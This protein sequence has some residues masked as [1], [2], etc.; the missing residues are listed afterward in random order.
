MIQRHINNIANRFNLFNPFINHIEGVRPLLRQLLD[1]YY[2]SKVEMNEVRERILGLC[3]SAILTNRIV[4]FLE[5]EIPDLAFEIGTRAGIPTTRQPSLPHHKRWG[6]VQ[7]VNSPSLHALTNGQNFVHVETG[8]DLSRALS[9]IRSAKMAVIDSISNVDPFVTEEYVGLTIFVDGHLFLLKTRT[10]SVTTININDFFSQ[11]GK[12]PLYAHG[13]KKIID[14]VKTIYPHFKPSCIVDHMQLSKI[15]KLDYS[16]PTLADCLFSEK[17][18]T[19]TAFSNKNQS[20]S[21]LVRDHM[22]IPNCLLHE[23]ACRHL[24]SDDWVEAAKESAA[25]FFKKGRK[26]KIYN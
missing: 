20:I 12:M 22:I 8:A 14:F 21:Q 17:Y 3:T 23:F 16:L 4:A 26:N 10:W 13:G 6:E 11:L 9:V 15:K 19:R 2:D 1:K 24:S 7:C 18:C 5:I 25:I